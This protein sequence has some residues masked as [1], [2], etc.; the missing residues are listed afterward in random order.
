MRPGLRL[1]ADAWHDATRSVVGL[2]WALSM[3][4]AQQA[5]RLFSA[6]PGTCAGAAAFDR[7]V[8]LARSDHDRPG[9]GVLRLA[10]CLGEAAAD[11]GPSL[12]TPALL[13]PLTWIRGAVDLAERGAAG[14]LLVPEAGV[15]PAWAEL[16]AKVEVFC[17]VREVGGWIGASQERPLPLLELIERSY[18]LEPFPAL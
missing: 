9:D 11:L 14:L 16:R 1:S 4:G 15:G 13:D 7:M 17:L 18:N 3:F 10:R 8:G 2:P 6:V 5:L 12:L